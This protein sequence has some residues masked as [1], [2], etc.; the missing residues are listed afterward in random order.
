MV[1]VFSRCQHHG[2]TDY[3][4]SSRVGNII[5]QRFY[6]SRGPNTTR[7]ESKEPHGTFMV[8][9]YPDDFESEID[10]A[11]KEVNAMIAK[12]ALTRSPLTKDRPKRKRIQ[13]NG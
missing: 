12:D 5:A 9:A 3:V 11:I 10:R 6:V 1:T 4:T 2:Y 13:R 8:W 7:I